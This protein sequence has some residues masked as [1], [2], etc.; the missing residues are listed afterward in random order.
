MLISERLG[1]DPNRSAYGQLDSLQR[2]ADLAKRSSVVICAVDPVGPNAS[3][4]SGGMIGRGGFQ[5]H[6]DMKYLAEETGGLF[7]ND[8]RV[9]VSLS[10]VLDDQRGYYLLGYTPPQDT[11]DRKLH[12]IK[13][14]MK[15]S[16]LKVFRTREDQLTSA[17][18]SPFNSGAV[19][20]RLTALFSNN[21]GK[22]SFLSGSLHIDINGIKFND[23]ADG[24][25]VANIDVL[26]MTF[27]DNGI[28]ADTSDKSFLIRLRS[29]G[30]VYSIDLPV[31]KP[32]GYQL[33]CVVRDSESEMVG[34]AS[35][36]I[37]VPD[38]SRGKLLLSRL[39]LNL[40]A[41]I[42]RLLDDPYANPTLRTFQQGHDLA[43]MF[44][45]LNAKRSPD[46]K[47]DL[48]MQI[49][50]YREG[51]LRYEGKPVQAIALTHDDPRYIVTGGHLRLGTDREPG[52][53]VLEVQMTDKFGK[54][55]QNIATQYIDFEITP[56]APVIP[57]SR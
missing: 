53:Y 1:F 35:Q 52:E 5:H 11:F 29:E 15:R 50:I 27:G 54:A 47:E 45:V 41:V 44:Q 38:V 3:I 34:S 51:K 28:P 8:N 21:S 17:I 49:R 2:Q 31:K 12:S 16:W 14:Q 23:E 55:K 19:P 22:G 46:G 40:R 32:G 39:F 56:V 37:E 4:G 7:V 20:V 30:F 13:V 9:V 26:T 10:K 48:E 36:F 6:A 43:Y 57:A 25:K 18:T 33:R 24:W 42:E